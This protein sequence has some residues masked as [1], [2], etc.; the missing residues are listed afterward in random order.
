MAF[1]THAGRVAVITGAAR[2]FGQAF[3]IGLAERGA[4]IVAVGDQIQR[5]FGRNVQTHYLASKMGIIGF[6][7][8]LASGLAGFGITVN[9]VGPT[10]TATRGMNSKGLPVAVFDAIVQKQAIKSP[11]ELEDIAG[12][13]AF[14][15]SDDGA[16]VTGQTIIADGGLAGC[17]RRTPAG[18]S[19]P[20][21]SGSRSLFIGEA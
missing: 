13:V 14:L 1:Q 18:N 4:D 7:R 11:G 5:E 2:G 20:H 16:F 17:S 3:C 6:T 21:R 15:S 19:G 10:A 9:A 8:G 12:T